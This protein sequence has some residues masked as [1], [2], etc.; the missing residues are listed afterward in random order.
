MLHVA[1]TDAMGS[2]V[3]KARYTAWIEHWIPEVEIHMLS[4]TRNNFAEVGQCAGLVLSGGGDVD[5][6]LYHRPDAVLI[7]RE[8]DKK[9]DAFEM[10]VIESALRRRMPVF[11]ICRGTQLFN[12]F[13][14][15]S[16]L[17]DIEAAGY[18]SHR[19]DGG[20]RRHGIDIV[21]GSSLHALCGVVSG[22]VNSSHHQ[23]IERVGHGMRVVARSPEG[24]IEA[25]EWEDPQ[26]HAFARLVQWHPE[27]MDDSENPLM[28]ALIQNFTAA[29]QH[30]ITS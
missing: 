1:L 18:Q 7:A 30:F 25:V 14:G 3:K 11:G 23:A 6:L 24:V 26:A 12:V 15:G 29:I 27:R 2:A 5:P 16:L 22:G 8:V 17:P 21:P 9:R 28:Y 13:H 10:R 4:Y 19:G 20:D